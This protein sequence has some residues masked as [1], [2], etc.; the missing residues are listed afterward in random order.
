MFEEIRKVIQSEA[1][2]RQV[3]D[4]A[5]DYGYDNKCWS[6][7]YSGKPCMFESYGTVLN[8][9]KTEETFSHFAVDELRELIKAFQDVN[10]TPL[11]GLMVHVLQGIIK[12]RVTTNE[13]Q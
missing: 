13:E 12:N 7:M 4:A 2:L 1:P 9:K 10:F 3:Y 5:V 11:A 8:F 6:N